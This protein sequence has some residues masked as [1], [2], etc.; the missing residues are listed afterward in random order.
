L[1]N[2]GG[3]TTGGAIPTHFSSCPTAALRLVPPMQ[4]SDGK[5]QNVRELRDPARETRFRKFSKKS[6]LGAVDFAVLYAYYYRGFGCPPDTLTRDVVANGPLT[7]VYGNR[8][9]ARAGDRG[10][11]AVHLSAL[12]LVGS[13]ACCAQPENRRRFPRICLTGAFFMFQYAFTKAKVAKTESRDPTHLTKRW[14]AT[15]LTSPLNSSTDPDSRMANPVLGRRKD[16]RTSQP[17]QGRA[18][19]PSVR[20]LHSVGMFYRLLIAAR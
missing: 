11:W 1:G 10:P 4:R 5:K 2:C 8:H 18:A 7:T 14:G 16:C 6:H 20:F 19:L 12:R 13:E 15:W 9:S 17:G 3:P